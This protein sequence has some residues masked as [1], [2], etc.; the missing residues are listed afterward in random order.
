MFVAI[1]FG[2]TNTDVA[3]NKDGDDILKKEFEYTS[4]KKMIKTGLYVTAIVASTGY[5][6]YKYVDKNKIKKRFAF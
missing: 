2:I 1:D 4:L 5:F 3:V 6:V